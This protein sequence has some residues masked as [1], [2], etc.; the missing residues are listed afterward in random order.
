MSSFE[1]TYRAEMANQAEILNAQIPAEVKAEQDKID[2]QA[3]YWKLHGESVA[4]VEKSLV[5]ARFIAGQ[6][7]AQE[8][9]TDLTIFRNKKVTTEKRSLFKTT[10]IDSYSEVDIFTGWHIGE[11]M[12]INEYMEAAELT[13]PVKRSNPLIT[14]HI[15]LWNGMLATSGK[16]YLLP[17]H[18]YSPTFHKDH[19]RLERRGTRLWSFN[20]NGPSL[21]TDYKDFGK[22]D[23]DNVVS[24]SYVDKIPASLEKALARFAIKKG[25]SLDGRL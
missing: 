9:P 20:N 14:K 3:K 1:E 10:Y 6:L 24:Y 21:L 7:I 22:V 18:N 13:K 2:R 5:V 25:V 8:T 15:Y 16:V 19:D 11:P 17:E 4:R 12:F 23:P